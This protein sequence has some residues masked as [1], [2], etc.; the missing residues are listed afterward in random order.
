MS[1]KILFT[2]I[3]H[4]SSMKLEM[5]G[6]ISSGKRRDQILLCHRFNQEKGD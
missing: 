4:T 3:T 2:E 5:N 6:K 1:N